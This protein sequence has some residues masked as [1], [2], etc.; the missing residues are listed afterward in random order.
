LCIFNCQELVWSREANHVS[1]VV[2]CQGATNKDTSAIRLL[3]T[4]PSLR[5]ASCAPRTL[6]PCV[7]GGGGS[8]GMHAR[9][10]ARVS[11]GARQRGHGPAG[12][13]LRRVERSSRILAKVGSWTEMLI[14]GVLREVLLAHLAPSLEGSTR[15]VVSVFG[16]C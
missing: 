6:T 8:L 14:G 15:F 7:A 5:R 2:V 3:Q 9:P 16:D 10:T 4:R 13:E 11:D 1:L 12:W